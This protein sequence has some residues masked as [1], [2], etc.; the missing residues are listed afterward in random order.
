MSH[1]DTDVGPGTSL[2]AERRLREL[3]ALERSPRV[4]VLVIGGGVTGVGVA[5]DA[6]ARGLS[7]ALAERHDLAFGTSRWSTK[8]VHG[9][10]RY[11]AAGQFAIARESA[12]ERGILIDRT[13][14]HLVH[15]LP[16]VLPLHR[17]VSTGA[18]AGLATTFHAGDVLRATAGT[19]ARTLP[20]ARRITPAEVIARAPTASLDGLRGGLEFWDGQLTDD[21]RLVV[22]I[23][24]TAA[25]LGAR[26]LT[27]VAASQATGAGAVLNDELGGRR[28]DVSARLVINAT[29][30]W[31]G[32]LAPELRLRP[33]RGTHLVCSQA[34]FGGLGCGLI[35]PVPGQIGR[36][37]FALPAPEHRVYV[38][39]TD[40]EAPGP[41]PDL[42]RPD[43]E[44]IAYLLATINL[45]LARELTS[46]D[47]LAT[48]SGLR[49]LLDSDAGTTADISRRHRV[50]IGSDGLVTIVGGKLTTYRRMAE[51]ALDTGLA[52]AGIDAR[53]C[54]T[55]R[56]ALVGAADRVAL[57]R[58]DAPLRL[59]RRYGTEASR[60]AGA[61]DP[62]LQRPICEGTETTA[63]EL[64]FGLRH[65]GALDAADLL[66]RRTRIGLDPQ[67][68]KRAE[69]A[70]AEIAA[71][72]GDRDI[73]AFV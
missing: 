61:A 59:V 62:E 15:P 73:A 32:E 23:A 41:I 36:T 64:W 37:V 19:S 60:V 34:A 47:V 12:V 52:H 3:E 7:V 66:D 5:L 22:T 48:Y 56:L 21:A 31:A 43:A 25:G 14:P 11:L 35:V 49:P 72:V 17:T 24:R 67:L 28:I 39:V 57:S 1:R 10:L 29:G 42:P 27:R 65:E 71:N 50:A 70:I 9:G 51:D 53:A 68:R 33:S 40:V 38:G 13:A 30:V 55:K 63:A 46:A 4:D 16:Q 18:A 44:E 6:A 8:M 58:V 2:N 54:V 26:I 45:A 20:R 69:P